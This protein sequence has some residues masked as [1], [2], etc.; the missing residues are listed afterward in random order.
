[1]HVMRP[2]ALALVLLFSAP[3]L[4]RADEWWAWSMLELWR[5]PPW[6]AGIFLGNRA[7]AEDGS[8][9]QM[10]SPRV[11]HATLPWLDLGAGLSMLNIENT[12]A[13]DWYRQLRP[14]LEINPRYDLTPHL[15]LEW[16]NRMEWRWNEE[17]SFTTHRTRHRLT[18]GWT[19]PSAQGPL[20][21]LFVSNEWLL[22]LHRR[23][24]TENRLVP[25]GFTCRFS[26]HADL[27]LFY[28]ID[29]SL[30]K[31]GWK[32]ESVLGTY[33]RVRF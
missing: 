3:A 13:H 26:E 2:L 23:D 17:A 30:L 24:W 4:L 11:K 31:T 9:M 8:T 21:R 20:T 27:D 6:T 14:E 10:I 12:T 1:M 33:L 5:Q 29:S 25:L 16:R 15:R 32:H 19:L 7:D 22:D 18:L 28:M